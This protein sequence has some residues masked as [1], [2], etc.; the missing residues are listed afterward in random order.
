M[1]KKR[2]K[3]A[4]H[5]KNVH[6]KREQTAGNV[7]VLVK[8]RET[9]YCICGLDS[10]FNIATKKIKLSPYKTSADVPKAI[11]QSQTFNPFCWSHFVHVHMNVKPNKKYI[12]AT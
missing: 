2:N 4:N 12:S 7:S 9:V 5:L 10:V 11:S 8:H 3:F 6:T 1:I